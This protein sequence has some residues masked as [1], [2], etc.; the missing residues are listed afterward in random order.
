MN[1]FERYIEELRQ[2]LNT[3]PDNVLQEK[4]LPYGRQFK[5]L[6]GN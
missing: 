3:L 4:E 2:K 5:V 1:D 6:R